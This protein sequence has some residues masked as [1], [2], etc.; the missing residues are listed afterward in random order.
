M[1]AAQKAAGSG[2]A[3]QAYD[4]QSLVI[5][6]CLLQLLLT[7]AQKWHTVIGSSPGLHLPDTG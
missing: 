7:P 4:R 1:V 6:A 5:T 3:C 2:S